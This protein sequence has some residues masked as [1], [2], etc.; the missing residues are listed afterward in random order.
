[1]P[2]ISDEEWDAVSKEL[3]GADDA[4]QRGHSVYPYYAFDAN[5]TIPRCPEHNVLLLIGQSFDG[6]KFVCPA[7]NPLEV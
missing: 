6:H 7:C 4:D 3:D 1:M 5:R 2:D